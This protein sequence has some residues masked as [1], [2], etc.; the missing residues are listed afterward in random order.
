MSIEEDKNKN[1]QAKGDR[2]CIWFVCWTV[3]SRWYP[4]G[5]VRIEDTELG[6]QPVQGGKVR[7]RRWFTTKTS[8][9]N[10]N[11]YFRTGSFRRP[12]NYSIVW[13]TYQ[14]SIRE[15]W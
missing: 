13:E 15:K 2:V 5:T 1:L 9:T 7:A 6:W 10:S 3:P 4:S 14:F 12:A 11:G 8:I